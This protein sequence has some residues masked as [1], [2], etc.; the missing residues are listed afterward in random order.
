MHRK[1]LWIKASAKCRNVTE[2]KN[3]LIR[4]F[5]YKNLLLVKWSDIYKNMSI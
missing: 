3:T 4:L 5:T 2:Q 1:S